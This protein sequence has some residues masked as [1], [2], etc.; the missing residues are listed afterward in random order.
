MTDTARVAEI[1]PDHYSISIYVPEF[2]LRFNH[3]LIKDDEPLLF[4]TGMKQMFPLVRDAVGASSIR[5]RFD[6][7]RS[8]ISKPTNAGH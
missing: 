1:A 4:H 2:N 7:S 8:A 6:G 5:P 3:F